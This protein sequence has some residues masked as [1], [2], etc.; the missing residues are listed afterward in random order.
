LHF[1]RFLRSGLDQKST[2]RDCELGLDALP[3][4]SSRFPRS[5]CTAYPYHLA[6]PRRDERRAACLDCTAEATDMAQR[7]ATRLRRELDPIEG[8]QGR[9]SRRRSSSGPLVGSRSGA[10]AELRSLRSPPSSVSRS[11][12]CCRG[13]ARPSRRP[14]GRSCP[15]R[16][17]RTRSLHALLA[18]WS[19][20]G[21]RVDGLSL[22]I[23]DRL[24]LGRTFKT[25]A[26]P[27]AQAAKAAVVPGAK[28]AITAGRDPLDASS[29]E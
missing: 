24:N 2:L 16:W 13:A 21:F 3:I 1:R 22:L 23:N 12:R 29:T 7:E 11:G 25:G 8:W 19:R 27:G 20:S 4:D 5:L 6:A 15:W 9:C 28:A 17:F 10:R 14:R 18:S 26:T